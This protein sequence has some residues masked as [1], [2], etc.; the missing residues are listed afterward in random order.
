MTVDLEAIARRGRCDTA[1]LRA[2]LPLIEQGYTPPFLARYRR[3]ELSGVDEASLWNLAHAL[4]AEKSTSQR[5]DELHQAWEQTTLADPALGQAIRKGNSKRMLDRLARRLK[6]EIAEQ[7][8]PSSR[9]AVRVMNPNRGDADD[10]LALA[11]SIE[12]IEDAESAVAGLDDAIA[13]RLA[14]DP[15]I[16]GAAVRWLAKNARIHIA[17]I[18]DPHVSGGDDD[19][20]HAEKES[21]EA[22]NQAEDSASDDHHDDD[23]H[24]D[25]SDTH[26]AHADSDSDSGSSIPKS[27]TSIASSIAAPPAETTGATTTD[28]ADNDVS[29]SAEITTATDAAA[30]AEPTVAAEILAAE[31]AVA[32]TGATDS[33]TDSTAAPEATS[34]ETVSAESSASQ[35]PAVETP[36]GAETPSVDSAAAGNA[37]AKPAKATKAAKKKASK[38]MA[39]PKKPKRVSPRQRRRRWLI[40]V[41][42]P[43][44]GKRIPASKLGSFQILMLSRAL[45]SQVAQCAFEYD[46]SKLV[47]EVQQTALAM[48]RTHGE[49][50]SQIVLQH[51]ADIREAAE[52]AWWDE[53]QEQASTRLVAIAGDHLRQVISRGGVEAKV[54]MS[55][56]AVGPRTAAT[57]IVAADGRILHSEDLPCQLSAALRAQAVSRMGELI[58]TYGVDLIVISNGPARRASMVAV[59]DLLAQSPEKSL[60]WTLADRSGAD[61]Y[62]GS[63]TADQEMR[64]TPRRFRAAAWLAFSVLTPG[65]AFAKVDPLKLRLVSFQR[66]LAEEALAET[67]DDVMASSASRGGV[68][69]NSAPLPW[70]G[71]L[72]GMTR[73]IAEQVDT[74]RRTSLFA[75]RAELENSV[76]WPSQVEARQAIAFLRVFGS[77]EPLDG[78]L[79]HPDDYALAHKLATTLEVELP[80]NSPPGYQTP[81]YQVAEKSGAAEIA[82]VQKSTEATSPAPDAIAQ[83]DESSESGSAETASA[84]APTTDD[85]AGSGEPSSSE[86]S[87]SDVA[88]E[89]APTTDVSAES[90]SAAADAEPSESPVEV[91]DTFGAEK[92]EQ[93]P[94]A[95][96]PAEPA[97]ASPAVEVA[98]TVV[99]RPKPEKAKVDKLIKEWQIGPKRTYQIVNWLCDP[100]GEPEAGGEPPAVLSS[101]PSLATLKPGDQVI[102][103][104]VGVMPFG[105]FVELA[106]DCSGLIHVSKVSESYVEDLHEAVQVGDVITTWVSRI[107][108]KRRRVA[109]S[110][111]SPEREAELEHHRH[112]RDDRSRDRGP[113]PPRGG[114]RPAGAARPDSAGHAADSRAPQ[115]GGGRGAN[116]RGDAARRG[117]GRSDS[118]PNKEGARGG[119]GGGTGGGG[120]GDSR[121]GG[122]GR[123]DSRG[124]RSRDNRDSRGGG[125]K[126][127]PESYRVESTAPKSTPISEAMEKGAE[128]LRSFGDL[129][130]FYSKKDTPAAKPEVTPKAEKK[131]SKSEPAESQST[132]SEPNE[133]SAAKET[134]TASEAASVPE[135]K[136]T[137]GENA[138]ADQP[139]TSESTDAT[140]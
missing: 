4:H 49:R 54:V 140:S 114:D 6:A 91:D 129:L 118:A 65:Q 79:I 57:S 74:R 94:A 116:P 80:P 36:A 112:Q 127:E 87:S 117:G 25:A 136:P 120:R 55:I 21:P 64:T 104:I 100:F 98:S 82:S 15:R 45:R 119:G 11:Q 97:S 23:H 62:A 32:E 58:H 53:L 56:D 37:D 95:E 128:P 126:R 115:A 44:A 113:R 63:G 84:D 8:T 135:A 12:G 42:Q 124:P 99:R 67:L 73:S 28:A 68:D 39:A 138:S 26:D 88:V 110:A 18:S 77:D 13:R 86:S 92:S 133:S 35:P 93:A 33:P 90:S 109:L 96:T 75:S 105:V 134:S 20:S 16:T 131:V 137:S 34:A 78:T 66:E 43:L 3:D 70:L 123:G 31:I 139:Q 132:T 61:A 24:D 122:G 108:E 81:N 52:A 59:G 7:V 106:P 103:V 40:S 46:A 125:R 27:A 10:L 50:L 71:R 30:T 72:P 107:D 102:G 130:Q 121:G 41:L 48:S 47:A 22:A 83:S 29:P 1:S 14:G 19:D 9:L 76:D 69:A 38:P 89:I 5:R 111:V 60:R 101:M 2:A 51:E 17:S 85:V